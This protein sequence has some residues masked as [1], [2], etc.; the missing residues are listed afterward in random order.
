MDPR[1]L[2]QLLERAELCQSRLLAEYDAQRHIPGASVSLL[3]NL[4][5]SYDVIR[6][7]EAQLVE[8]TRELWA[9][10]AALGLAAYNRETGQGLSSQADARIKQE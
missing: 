4:M 8:T 9:E 2:Q 7:L 5:E 6:Q 1:P 3:A 10:K